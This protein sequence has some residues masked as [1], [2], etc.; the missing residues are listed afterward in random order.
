[1]HK[2]T[3]D[4]AVATPAAGTHTVHSDVDPLTS[5]IV[6][7]PGMELKRLTPSNRSKL[8]FD[9][10]LWVARAEE[11]HAVLR[12]TLKNEGV[13]VL[14][15]DSLLT[16]TME[17]PEA[18]EFVFETFFDDRR[19][20]PA[21][22]DPVREALSSLS[23]P[24]LVEVLIGGMTKRELL[25]F[26]Q[27]PRS[28]WFHTLGLDDFVVRPL[29]NHL[30]T[31]DASTWIGSGVAIHTMARRARQREPLHYEAIY[32][33]HPRFA[34]SPQWTDLDDDAPASVEGGDILVLGG[35]AVAVGV[36]ERTTP[37]GVERL[38]QRLFAAGAAS[39]VLGIALP[40]ARAYMHLDTVMA[41]VDEHSFTKYAG[42]GMLPTFTVTPG[43]ADG[44][45]VIQDNPPEDMHR[46]IARAIGI[47]EVRILT[48]V[49]DVHAA[50]REQWDDGCN[51]LAVRPGVV[52]GYDRT[53]T[54]NNHL[55]DAGVTVIEV[56]GSEL[57]RGRGGPRC[58][59][60]PVSRTSL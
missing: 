8:L 42:L 45:L 29:P 27:E 25:E 11:E 14:V 37:Q 53:T 3:D 24:A 60:C 12:W 10:I 31:R 9:E 40:T 38:A 22:N 18:R 55:R 28:L 56:P 23:T 52:L 17:I 50:E 39:T 26:A 16:E 6:H 20:G 15:L 21:A 32:R 7:R 48:P 2:S 44:E 34:G 13:E 47:E 4:R 57:G 36:S 33:Y 5:V 46:A 30:F 35:G 59:T 51:V 49:Q 43:D 54:T 19:F 58:M 1:M 41:M